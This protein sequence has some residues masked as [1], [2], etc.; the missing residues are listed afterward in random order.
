MI[1]CKLKVQNAFRFLASYCPFSLFYQKFAHFFRNF[2]AGAVSSKLLY[3]VSES[4]ESLI[5][6]K[7][8]D[9][10]TLIDWSSPKLE[11]AEGFQ[12]T[13][14][15]A[16]IGYR[17]VGSMNWYFCYSKNEVDQRLQFHY[18]GEW[19]TTPR[20]EYSRMSRSTIRDSVQ[21]TS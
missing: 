18:L 11:F 12:M 20:D 6:V 3:N 1:A 4:Q 9:S 13:F 21:G 17:S 15:G 5:T 19:K 2:I 16:N 7:K 14:S 10:R 8:A